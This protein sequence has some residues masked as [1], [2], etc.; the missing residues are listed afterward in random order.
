MNRS[1]GIVLR[2]RYKS[3]VSEGVAIY[4][5]MRDTNNLLKHLIINSQSNSNLFDTSHK[6]TIQIKD[7]ITEINMDINEL[8]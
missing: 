7:D 2:H 5:K 8:K 4:K 3:Y 6:I 1:E